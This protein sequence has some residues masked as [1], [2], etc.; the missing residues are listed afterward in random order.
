MMLQQ[1][2]SDIDELNSMIPEK[3]AL[4]KDVSF[5]GTFCLF[6]ELSHFETRKWP[7]LILNA[8][9]FQYTRPQVCNCDWQR[10]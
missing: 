5:H 7:H 9:L 8:V 10:G 3:S 4:S 6:F 2:N 1:R